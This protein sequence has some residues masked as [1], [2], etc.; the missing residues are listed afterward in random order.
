MPQ[1]GSQ[2][3]P[4]ADIV[5]IRVET[6]E[7][8]WAL[9]DETWAQLERLSWLQLQS[10]RRGLR[11]I[12]PRNDAGPDPVEVLGPMTTQLAELATVE[13]RDDVVLFRPGTGTVR[14]LRQRLAK[15]GIEPLGMLVVDG[16]PAAVV[17][18]WRAEAAR[19]AL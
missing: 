15:A 3:P 7:T 11:G 13:L 18:S 8:G 1:E 14:E 19:A 12:V 9:A 6:T 10:D 2:P 4:L 16:Q 5:T 17:E